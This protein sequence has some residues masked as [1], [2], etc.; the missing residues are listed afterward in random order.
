MLTRRLA[1]VVSGVLAVI[2]ALLPG[3]AAAAAAPRAATVPCSWP[4]YG[5]DAG[6]S[7]AQSRRCTEIHRGTVTALTPAWFLPTAD[8]V[9]ASP[10]VVGGTAYVGSW[11]GVMHAINQRTGRERW[12]FAIGDTSNTA[13]GRIE[14]SAAV[15]DVAG[16]RVVI[17][18]GGAT[19]YVLDARNGRELTSVCVDPRES[20][21]DRCQGNSDGA[22]E[23]E[24]SPAV[25]GVGD[26]LEVVVGMDVHNADHVGRTGVVSFGLSRT[27]GWTL[28]PRWKFDPETRRTYTGPALLTEGAGAGDGCASVWSSPAVD[29]ANNMVFFGTGSCSA[30]GVTSGESMWGIRLSDGKFVWTFDAH[31]PE[32]Y[33][34][35]NWDDDFGASPNLLPGGLV[36]EGSKGGTYYA[37]D[38]LTGSLRWE[39]HAGQAGHV[40]SGFAVGGMIGSAA[41]GRVNGRPAVFATTAISTPLRA[42]L[43]E[44]PGDIDPALLDDPGRLFSIHAMSVE[45]GSILWR[46]PLSRASYGAAS[47]ANGVVFAPS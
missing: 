28:E 15:V 23:I 4:M 27:H 1:A 44:N 30:P 21:A 2:G 24:S 41:V 47:Y 33:P 14:S 43:D 7:F 35:R 37:L 36:G 39:T 10:A 25:V 38:R 9:T 42:P 34:S 26:H 19:V 32:R 22:I 13:F 6:R 16:R 31:A 3:A 45:D 29:V 17:F 5:H 8:S 46:S 18:G 11:D 12:R 20:G 40:T